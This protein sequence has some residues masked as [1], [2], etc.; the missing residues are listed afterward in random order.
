MVRTAVSCEDDAIEFV[1]TGL[2]LAKDATLHAAK[3]KGGLLALPG[4]QFCSRSESLEFAPLAIDPLDSAFYETHIRFSVSVH[5]RYHRFCRRETKVPV[6]L[7]QRR[8]VAPFVSGP[9]G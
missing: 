7:G 9:R 1:G 5:S 6:L 3:Y 8:Q 2:T 4:K